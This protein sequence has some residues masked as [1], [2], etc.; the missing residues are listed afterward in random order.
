MRID[1]GDD[2]DDDET[3]E[4][5]GDSTSEAGEVGVDDTDEDDDDE[6]RKR[7]SKGTPPKSRGIAVP[8]SMRRIRGKVDNE[9]DPLDLGESFGG[10]SISPARVDLPKVLTANAS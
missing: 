4:S 8:I 6:P 10:M 3:D 7:E 1:D 2:G 9:D 5:E